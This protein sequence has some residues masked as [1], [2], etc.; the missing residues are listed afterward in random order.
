MK[1]HITNKSILITGAG[2]S[3]G[4]ELCRQILYNNPKVIVILD[5]SEIAL[6]E[7]NNELLETLK[8]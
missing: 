4:K 2:G 5:I 1:K 6:Y 7:I 3:I 8:T